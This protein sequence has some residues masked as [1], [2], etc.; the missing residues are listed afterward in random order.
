MRE[1]A[2]FRIEKFGVAVADPQRPTTD[3]SAGGVG[4]KLRSRGRRQSSCR[5]PP[6][7][8]FI[9]VTCGAYEQR[10]S[11]LAMSGAVAWRME[12][13][14]CDAGARHAPGGSMMPPPTSAPCGVQSTLPCKGVAPCVRQSALGGEEGGV[15]A[16]VPMREGA[17]RIDLREAGKQ[18]RWRTVVAS[19]ATAEKVFERRC[20]HR[21]RHREFRSGGVIEARASRRDKSFV[22]PTAAVAVYREV[23]PV[24]C[25]VRAFKGQIRKRVSEA[26]S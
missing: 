16:A 2:A 14:R 23:R 11:E 10:C 22:P 12:N 6:R 7:S 17:R 4:E 1:A 18:A 25:D 3:G 5:Q 24:N 19:I 21:A 15:A 26:G 13:V 9:S 8:L 20:R